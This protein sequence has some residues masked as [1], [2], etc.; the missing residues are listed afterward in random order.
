M[1]DAPAGGGSE[2]ERKRG[3]LERLPFDGREVMVCRKTFY[4]FSLVNMC[5]IQRIRI[6]ILMK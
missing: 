3:V 1:C 6:A 4:C 5:T 2:G